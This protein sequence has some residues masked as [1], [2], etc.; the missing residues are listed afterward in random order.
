MRGREDDDVDREA[1]GGWTGMLI[2]WL[3]HG[4][5]TGMGKPWREVRARRKMYARHILGLTPKRD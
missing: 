3:T 5:W 4:R 1:E 2:M